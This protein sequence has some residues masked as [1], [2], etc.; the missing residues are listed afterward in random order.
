M[1]SESGSRRGQVRQAAAAVTVASTLRLVGRR[2]VLQNDNPARLIEADVDHHR[3][4]RR[5]PPAEH[6][7]RRAQP[8]NHCRPGAVATER[9]HVEVAIGSPRDSGQHLVAG[10]HSEGLDDTVEI[11]AEHR[12]SRC[13]RDEEARTIGGERER[14]GV[15]SMPPCAPSDASAKAS[16]SATCRG[17]AGS[18]ATT[19]RGEL[20]IGLPDQ[21]VQLLAVPD[22]VG[23]AR[24]NGRVGI[25]DERQTVDFNDRLAAIKRCADHASGVGLELP[26]LLA[27]GPVGADGAGLRHTDRRLVGRHAPRLRDVGDHR[28]RYDAILTTR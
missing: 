6:R 23:G 3:G 20:A 11:G 24:G 9:P 4:P 18:T 28:H 15:G 17:P 16:R 19:L 5:R 26:W 10:H 22:H 13:I 2:G 7:S 12:A 27:L 1:G 21:G 25:V 8:P 14:V